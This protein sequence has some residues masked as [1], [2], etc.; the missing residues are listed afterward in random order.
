[1]GGNQVSGGGAGGGGKE[2]GKDTSAMHLN[3]GSMILHLSG[4]V[5]VAG[6]ALEGHVC[7]SH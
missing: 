6:C 3:N 4:L 7:A 5:L 1:M 2:E